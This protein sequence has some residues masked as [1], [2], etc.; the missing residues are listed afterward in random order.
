MAAAAAAAL[1]GS[2]G[3]ST[4]IDGLSIDVEPPPTSLYKK[5]KKNKHSRTRQ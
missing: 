1:V 5:A 4:A 3:R 2:V